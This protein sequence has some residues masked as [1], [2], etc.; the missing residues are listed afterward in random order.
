MSKFFNYF[1]KTLYFSDRDQPSLDTI[2]NLTFKFKFNDTFKD[3]SVVYYD[4]I[5]PEGETPEILADKFYNSSERH[6]IILMVNNIINPLLDWPM[7]YTTLNKFINSK[8]STNNYA[9]TSNTS[10]SGLSWAESN[11]K[12]YFV[13]EKKIILNTGEYTEKTIFLTQQDYANTS[14]VTTNNY[15]LGDSTQIELRRTRGT[16]TYYEYEHENNESKRT[17]KLLK[18]EFVPLLE[19]EFKEL[20]K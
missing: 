20:T 17:I 15:T 14:P 2:T 13:K 7:S 5:V 3:N 12:E 19:K 6:W 10:V 16:K 9:D 11:T 8:Y 4:Y 18:K 1:P